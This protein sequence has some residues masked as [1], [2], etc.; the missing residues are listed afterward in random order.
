MLLGFITVMLMMMAVVFVGYQ[1]LSANN[2]SMET[3]VNNHNA[4]TGYIIEDIGVDFVQG[5]GIAKPQS[6]KMLTTDKL[7]WDN[8]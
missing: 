2:R 8:R 6:L 1:Q 4:K 7:N 5:Y 3:I